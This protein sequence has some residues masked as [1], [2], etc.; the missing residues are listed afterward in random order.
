MRMIAMLTKGFKVEPRSHLVS[1]KKKKKKKKTA[2][3][4]TTTIKTEN[5]QRE[6]VI[7]DKGFSFFKF[8]ILSTIQKL[9]VKL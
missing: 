8:S 9:I 2:A 7:K 6:N 1:K 3:T 4:T 5:L